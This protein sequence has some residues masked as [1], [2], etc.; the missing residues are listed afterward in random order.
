MKAKI[1][2]LMLL[3]SLFAISCDYKSKIAIVKNNTNN[4]IV[5]GLWHDRYMTDSDLYYNK[6]YI[7]YWIA[8]KQF[9]VIAIPGLNINTAPDSIKKYLY[10]FNNDT[11][12]KY[13]KLKKYKGIMKHS[14]L[15][16]IEIQ[17]NK[18]KSPLDTIY[19]N[20]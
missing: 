1:K 19:V 12:V 20:Q 5:G 4:L 2:T 11:V 18:V 8:P 10:F 16:R 6:I 9:N 13:Q 17:I 3:I 14:L 7:E 15:N